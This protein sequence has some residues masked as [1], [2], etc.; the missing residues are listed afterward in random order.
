MFG[1]V[2]CQLWATSGPTHQLPDWPINLLARKLAVA[3]VA[4]V[5]DTVT[6]SAAAAANPL[7]ASKEESSDSGGVCPET[8]SCQQAVPITNG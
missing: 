2:C 5:I 4:A 8:S 1:P 6:G 7:S 3:E